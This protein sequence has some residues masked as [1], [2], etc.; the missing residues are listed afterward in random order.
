MLSLTA[1]NAAT[2]I[3]FAVCV[4]KMLSIGTCW[5]PCSQLN[6]MKRFGRDSWFVGDSVSDT[7]LIATAAAAASLPGLQQLQHGA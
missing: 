1:R 5:L 4:H 3:M 6:H 7:E 2:G